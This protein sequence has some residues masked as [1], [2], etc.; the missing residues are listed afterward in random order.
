MR[1]AADHGQHRAGRAARTTCAAQ[2]AVPVVVD[3]RAVRT[4]P[5]REARRRAGAEA[6][7]ARALSGAVRD[8]R[9]LRA[10][11]RRPACAAAR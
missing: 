7:A 9:A 10:L 2:A 1:A 3:A 5:D 11:R 4:S 8:S 6:R